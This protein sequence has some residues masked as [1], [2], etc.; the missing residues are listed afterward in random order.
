MTFRTGIRRVA[1]HSTIWTIKIRWT[2]LLLLTIQTR[3]SEFPIQTPSIF[4]TTLLT[5]LHMY[6]HNSMNVKPNHTMAY[7]LHHSSMLRWQYML[8]NI[9]N[10]N[11]WNLNFDIEKFFFE[12]NFKFTNQLDN[13]T[14][15]D[16][17]YSTLDKTHHYYKLTLQTDINPSDENSF[18]NITWRCTYRLDVWSISNRTIRSSPT[19]W[20]DFRTCSHIACIR[21]CTIIIR[22]T[23][24]GTLI[25]EICRLTIT[26]Q[27]NS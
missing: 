22:N 21:T 2:L 25:S 24:N 11:R 3:I 9:D 26:H 6:M 13:S 8:T 23:S 4:S 20:T 10:L 18:L 27:T 1:L 5:H 16:S 15:V 17:H 12:R 7:K 19:S 14:S